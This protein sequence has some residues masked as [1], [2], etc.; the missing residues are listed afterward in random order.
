MEALSDRKMQILQSIIVNYLETAEP[1]GSRTISRQL[2]LGL[3]PATI[4]NEMSDLE[5]MGLIVQPHTSAGRIP[6]S[7]GY[8]VYV[9]T[10]LADG[11]FPDTEETKALSAILADKTHQVDSAL[12]EMGNIMSALTCYPTVVSLPR[13][14]SRKLKHLQIIGLDEKTALLVIVTDGNVAR[15]HFL[16]INRALSQK[17]SDRLSTILNYQLQGRTIEEINLPLINT[18]RSQFGPDQVIL[19]DVLSAIEETVRTTEDMEYY[20][21]GMNNLL[22]YPEFSDASRARGLMEALEDKENIRLAL[23]EEP[24]GEATADDAQDYR[25]MIGTENPVAQMQDC[26]MVTTSITVGGK[27][28]G[29]ISVIGPVRMDYGKVISALGSMVAD[30]QNIQLSETRRNQKALTVQ[31]EEPKR[32]GGKHGTK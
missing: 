5:E 18:I 15:N 28:L 20:A 30:F 13:V 29:S 6:T 4:R 22:D 25:I 9:D 23:G 24:V 17:E 12:K 19:N 26:S 8:R 16:K 10:L 21:T 31:K 7:K 27:K 14:H 11:H 3:S 32:T 2:P 1:V